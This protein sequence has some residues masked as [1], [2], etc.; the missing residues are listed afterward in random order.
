M[1]ENDFKA[2][3]PEEIPEID[4]NQI[5]FLTR[6]EIRKFGFNKKISHEQ[7]I[8]IPVHLRP[9]WYRL[10]LS[11]LELADQIP[12]FPEKDKIT[13]MVETPPDIFKMM[14]EKS[15]KIQSDKNKI[16]Y[17]SPI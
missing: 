12:V 14:E 16:E 5:P 11:Y 13:A 3:Y 9:Q 17:K 15:K 8:K 1:Y 6:L 7:L 10:N 2:S 4:L